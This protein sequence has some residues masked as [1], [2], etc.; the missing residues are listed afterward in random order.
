MLP[1]IGFLWQRA[2]LRKDLC[3]RILKMPSTICS[4]RTLSDQEWERRESMWLSW[5][6]TLMPRYHPKRCTPIAFVPRRDLSTNY[7]LVVSS[8]C[9]SRIQNVEPKSTQVTYVNSSPPSK[10]P[11]P[12]GVMIGSLTSTK[13]AGSAAWFRIESSPIKGPKQ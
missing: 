10:M 13:P 5:P 12:A 4:A 11:N 6:R 1:R 9:E 2:T 3:P 8:S 7:W